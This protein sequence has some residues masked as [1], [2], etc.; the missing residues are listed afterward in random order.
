MKTALLS[1]TKLLGLRSEIYI[2]HF[3]KY[4]MNPPLSAWV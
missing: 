2:K 1:F 4:N 3:I